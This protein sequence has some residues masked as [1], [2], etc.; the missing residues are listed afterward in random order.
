VDSSRGAIENTAQ[1]RDLE[2]VAQGYH[3]IYESFVQRYA[4]TLQNSSPSIEARVITEAIPPIVKSW[5]RT[6]LILPL[7]VCLGLLIGLPI[8]FGRDHLDRKLR[9]P[10]Q[11]RAVLGARCLGLLAETAGMDPRMEAD[12]PA[13]RAAKVAVDV[14]GLSRPAKVTGI[15]SALPHEGKT[16][17]ATMLGMLSA[18]TGTRTLLIDACLGRPTLTDTLAPDATT[19]LLDLLTSHAA[20]DAAVVTHQPSGLHFLPAAAKDP[21]DHACHHFTLRS[22]QDV[23]ERARSEYDSVIMD[24]PSIT[25]CAD[26]WASS[27]LLDGMILVIEWGRTDRGTVLEALRSSDLTNDQVIGVLLNKVDMAAYPRFASRRQAVDRYFDQ[28][29]RKNRRAASLDALWPRRLA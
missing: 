23:L 16:T 10:S 17:V 1:L 29:G 3:S 6:S 14:R 13:I 21:F 8:A 9:S 15:T 7:G 5:P 20:L 19:G 26:V 27:S 25:T 22:M 18:K 11:V 2:A 28:D 24:L 12:N 4:E